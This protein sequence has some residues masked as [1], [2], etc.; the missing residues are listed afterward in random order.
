MN[1]DK[2]PIYQMGLEDGY[3]G[4]PPE[5]RFLNVPRTAEEYEIWGLGHRDG[6]ALKD[7]EERQSQEP[8]AETNQ[9]ARMLGYHGHVMGGR[10]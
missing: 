6:S 10:R 4:D 5:Q 7:L 3:N 1:L 9:F 8:T 2:H